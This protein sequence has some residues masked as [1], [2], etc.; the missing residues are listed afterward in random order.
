VSSIKAIFIKQAKDMFKNPMVLVQF[1]IFPAVA[2]VMTRLI[3]LPDYEAGNDMF[4]TNMFVP[5]MAAVFAGMA[6]IMSMAG[7]IAEDKELKSLRFLVIA[8]V[9]P[10]QY[11]IGTGGFVLLAGCV[12]SVVFALIGDFTLAESGKFLAVMIPSV[13]AS[14]ILGATIGIFF[15]NQQA[16]TAIGMPVAMILGFTPMIANFNKTIERFASV[17]YTQQLNV[18]VNDLTANL[19]RPLITIGINIAVLT[20]VFIVVYKKKGLKG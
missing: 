18:I 10:H 12:T 5:M 3:V 16:S 7:I 15:N 1:I 9:K 17:L 6:L 4:T 19:M 13:A 2:F 14:I 11:L 8:G 20:V